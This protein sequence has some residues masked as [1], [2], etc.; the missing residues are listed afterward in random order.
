MARM[1]IS[2]GKID[3]IFIS[4]LHGDHYLGLVPLLFSM[5]LHKR[6]SELHLYG[7]VGLDEI[8]TLQLKYS[9]SVLN[10][11]ITF[12]P[13]DPSSKQLLLENGAITVESIP[14]VHKLACAG[15]LFREKQKPRRIDKLKLVEGMKLQQ[16]AAFKTGEDI[17]D[18]N[19]NLLYKNN[20]FTLPPRASLAYAYCSDTAWNPGMI[21][22][23]NHIDLLYHE[24]TF[25]QA[26]LIRAT[27]TKHSTAAQAG[28]MAKLAQ[29]KKLVIGHFSA[30]YKELDI[31][32]Q[33]AKS[34]FP[35]TEL[36]VEGTTFTLAD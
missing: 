13:F 33:E 30:R 5:N 9:E 17:R 28:E 12:H 3:H 7:P 35:N 11:Q 26:D 18:E 19:G 20:D 29:V 36:A 4:H 21:D 32:L 14:L 6:A 8:I 15:F 23:I 25:A 24:A 1:Q 31:L 2:P 10:Y 34:H 22:Q 27:E 16:I